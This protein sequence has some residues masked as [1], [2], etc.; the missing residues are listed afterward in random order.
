MCSDTSHK[1]PLAKSIGLV[2]RPLIR[3]LIRFEFT[4]AE[5]TELIRQAYVEVAYDS[6]GIEGQEMTI[7]RAA[8]L[9][10]LSRKEVLRLRNLA[11]EN[12]TSLK[13]VPNRA[14]RVV[15]GWLS[16]T[17]FLDKKSEPKVLPLKGSKG[18]FMSL[19]TKYSGDIT[20][21]AVL[22]ELNLVKVTDQPEPDLVK[23][24]N[25]AYIP[26]EDEMEQMRILST[27]VSDMLK[28]GVQNIETKDNKL[29]QRQVVFSQMDESAASEFRQISGEKASSLLDEFNKFLSSRR[30]KTGKKQSDKTKRVGLGIYYLEEA[31]KGQNQQKK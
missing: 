15:H 12:T 6:F 14:Q 5:L 29:F 26:H 18:S 27:C 2:L 19:C 1:L 9:T 7:S 11:L 13:T 21:G 20:Y 16:D 31:N 3:L 24:V 17:E 8:V 28:T 23:L 30:G 10:G 22:D 4:H 25:R